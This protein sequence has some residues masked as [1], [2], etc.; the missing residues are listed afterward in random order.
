LTPSAAKWRLALGKRWNQCCRVVAGRVILSL[1]AG[2][3]TGRHIEH[4]LTSPTIGT[5]LSPET[6]SNITDH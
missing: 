2:V 3:V 4:H 5:E 6:I 1:Y